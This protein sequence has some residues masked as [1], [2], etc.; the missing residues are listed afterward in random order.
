MRCRSQ[1]I[2]ENPSRSV[3]PTLGPEGVR[4]PS[5]G[6]CQGGGWEST[7][8]EAGGGGDGIRG[9]L[10]GIPGKGKTFEM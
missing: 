6:E 4:C 7:L 1:T 5:V 2:I 8:R 3:I 9:F 10:K